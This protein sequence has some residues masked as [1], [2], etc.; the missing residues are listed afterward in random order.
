VLGS[1]QTDVP[2]IRFCCRNERS[3]KPWSVAERRR[4]RASD[5]PAPY[6]TATCDNAQITPSARIDRATCIAVTCRVCSSIN[7][8]ILSLLPFSVWSCTKSQLH[9]GLGLCA[10]CRRAV[11][12]PTRRILRCRLF[13]KS[14]SSRRTRSTRFAFTFLPVRSKT[15]VTRR[16]PYQGCSRLNVTIRSLLSRF[17]ADSSFLR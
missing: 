5:F 2:V 1:E 9:T 11:E 10:L 4:Q 7:V 14:P 15:A 8:R 12:T 17:S 16:Y 13:T 3:E 6:G